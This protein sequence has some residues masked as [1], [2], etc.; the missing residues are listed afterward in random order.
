[1]AGSALD[2]L[3]VPIEVD[4]D[5]LAA[6]RAAIE[7][8]AFEATSAGIARARRLAGVDERAQLSDRARAERRGSFAYQAFCRAVGDNGPNTSDTPFDELP[9]E[10]RRG[11]IA[12]GNAAAAAG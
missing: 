2:P 11:W 3:Q 12:A 1:M 10:L 4:T 8:G 7:Q 6:F 9:A 5:S